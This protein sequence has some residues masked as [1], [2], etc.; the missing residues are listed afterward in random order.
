VAVVPVKEEKK[1]TFTE[2]GGGD[3][4]DSPYVLKKKKKASPKDE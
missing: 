1:R 3:V 4:E 2:R